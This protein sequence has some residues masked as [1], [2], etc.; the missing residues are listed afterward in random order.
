LTFNG[1]SQGDPTN[2][3]DDVDAYALVNLYTGI[4]SP[5]GDWEVSLFAKNIF[6]AQRVL[7]R[8]AIAY[9]A[10]VNVGRTG[11]NLPTNYRAI[12]TTQP[13]EFGLNVRYAFGS[14]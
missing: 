13:R 1:K 6:D 5:E 8:N 3:Y 11:V 12:T 2:Q 10:S 4:R 9:Q 14:R 7:T